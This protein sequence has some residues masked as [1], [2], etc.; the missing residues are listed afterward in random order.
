[1]NKT[2]K[3]VIIGISAA[4]IVF[5]FYNAAWF[6]HK[7]YKYTPYT[8]ELKEFIEN[9]SYVL[10]AEDGYLYNVKIPDYLSF[11]GNLCVTEPEQKCSLLIWPKPFGKF[12]YGV[13]IKEDTDV[14][15]IELNEDFTAKDSQFDEIVE[16]YSDVIEDLHDK[17]V[18]MWDVK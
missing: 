11:T 18:K 8:E 17:S 9:K 12:K 7:E 4:V 2:V 5:G 1:M 16:K 15:Q 10:T 14:Y 13:I 6:C 3:R